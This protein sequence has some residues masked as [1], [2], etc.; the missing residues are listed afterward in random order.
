M[1]QPP[2]LDARSCQKRRCCP[3]AVE[4]QWAPSGRCRGS[5]DR[6]TTRL[7][8]IRAAAEARSAVHFQ[9]GSA[10]LK[11]S[12]SIYLFSAPRDPTLRGRLHAGLRAINYSIGTGLGVAAALR[13][14]CL[15]FQ[16]QTWSS[17]SRLDGGS[18]VG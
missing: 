4:Q 15:P 6:G 17:V 12:Q 7:L 11:S 1:L 10:G 14:A 13:R 18:N 2:P 5:D 8:S 16:T 3:D 9:C